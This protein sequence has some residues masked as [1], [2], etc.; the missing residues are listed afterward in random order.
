MPDSLEG[1]AQFAARV[2]S[3][4]TE[5]R[6]FLVEAKRS[7]K[8]VVGLGASTKGNVLLQ[9]FGLGPDL[10]PVIAEVNADKFGS[11]TPGTLI[12]IAPESEVLAASPDYLLVLPWHF[13]EFFVRHPAFKGRKLLFPLP[14]LEI[15]EP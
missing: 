1:F 11:F 7:G 3:A 4:R 15:V 10:L 8:R 12:P 6:N 13:R 5:L 9:Y 14:R 2:D